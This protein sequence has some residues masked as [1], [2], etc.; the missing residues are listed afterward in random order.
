MV[1]GRGPVLSAGAQSRSIYLPLLQNATWVY[2]WNGTDAGSGGQRVTVN[3]SAIGDFPL[4]LRTPVAPPAPRLPLGSLFSPS[5]SDVVTCASAQCYSEQE[6]TGNYSALFTEGA[7]LATG[8]PLVVAGNTYQTAE[9][10]N[11]W[12][13]LLGDNADSIAG[14]PGPS[15]DAAV[16]P[17]GF[18]L[19][20]QAPGTV[21]LLLFSK[22]YNASHTDIAAFAS[23]QGIAWAAAQG[24]SACGSA[25]FVFEAM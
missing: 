13:Q 16:I 1:V 7:V 25:G 6:P 11:Y 24:Y 2:Y 18:V 5:R 8:E 23:Q 17:N 21:P 20:S 3:T 14:Q 12:S 10:T 4:F 22:V 9:L 19:A 15:Y